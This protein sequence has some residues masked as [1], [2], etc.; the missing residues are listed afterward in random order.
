MNTQANNTMTAEQVDAKMTE[1]FNEEINTLKRVTNNAKF[2]KFAIG[3][4]EA[5]DIN[6][7][8]IRNNPTAFFV[9]AYYKL[10]DIEREDNVEIIKHI[11]A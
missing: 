3:L 8:D 5:I 9:S 6:I 7:N 1:W 10:R 2:Q 4:G 11:I